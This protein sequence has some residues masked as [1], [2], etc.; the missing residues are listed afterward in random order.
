MHIG[1]T[2]F[3]FDFFLDIVLVK[4]DNTLL[5]LLKVCNMMKSFKNIIFELF[6]VAL[7]FIKNCLQGPDLIGE[8]L[9]SHSEIINNQSQVLVHSIK[10]LQ[11]LSHLIGLFVQFL[12]IKLPWSN[13]S[14]KLL[15]LVIKHKLELL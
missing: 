15:D 10:M 1:I 3:I 14:L 12:D 8:T 5:E 13:I 2:S 11:F 7:L 4:T 6:L 9:L